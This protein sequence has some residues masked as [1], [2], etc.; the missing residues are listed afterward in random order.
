MVDPPARSP[1]AVPRLDLLASLLAF[2]RGHGM[3]AE[4]R[5]SGKEALALLERSEQIGLVHTVSNV[6][7]GVGYICNCCGCCCGR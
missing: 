6:M 7:E 3:D 2:V 4:G 1:S 5:P